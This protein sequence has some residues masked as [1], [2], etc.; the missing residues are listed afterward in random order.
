MGVEAALLG[1]A[2]FAGAALAGDVSGAATGLSLI[3]FAGAA[4]FATGLPAVAGAAAAFGFVTG[5][6][7]A[8]LAAAVVGFFLTGALAGAAFYTG[9]TFFAGAL[10]TVFFAAGFF[11]AAGGA[12]FFAGD[13]FLATDD[14]LTAALAG[15]LAA[16]LTAFFTA[17]FA[18]FLTATCCVPCH[19]LGRGS[20]VLYPANPAAATTIA[21]V[22]IAFADVP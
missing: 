7:G 15:A 4:F 21:P 17:F 19:S 8:A 3:D 12:A 11:A 16:G 14:F 1:A 20:G 18:V 5:F 10:A 9:A 6:D 13:A 22:F 2:G